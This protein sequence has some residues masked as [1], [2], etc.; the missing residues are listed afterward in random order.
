MTVSRRNCCWKPRWPPRAAFGEDLAGSATQLVYWRMS[1]GAD[2]GK[3]TSLYDNAPADLAAAV[4]GSRDRL[5]DLIDAFDQPDRAYLSRPH[6]D[7]ALRFPDYEQ[8]ARVA[9]WSS[10]GDADD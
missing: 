6:P 10:A 9:E 3:A 4:A 2:P 5:C 7:R 1:G 8:L